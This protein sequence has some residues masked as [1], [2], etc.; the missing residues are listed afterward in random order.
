MNDKL[1]EQNNNII[2]PAT[3]HTSTP[4]V[5]ETT[6]ISATNQCEWNIQH[7]IQ[8][9]IYQFNQTSDIFLSVLVNVSYKLCSEPSPRDWNRDA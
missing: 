6:F 4:C 9:H 2:V 3:E 1:R 7:I 5:R 8:F